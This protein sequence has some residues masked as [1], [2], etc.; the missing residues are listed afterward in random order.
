MCCLFI[1]RDWDNA[2]K[3]GWEKVKPGW[4]ILEKEL[5]SKRVLIPTK[6]CHGPMVVDV[7]DD[8]RI[9]AINTNSFNINTSGQGSRR[10]TIFNENEFYDEIDDYMEEVPHRN[11]II[12]ATRSTLGKSAGYR[13]ARRHFFH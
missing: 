8:L 4:R 11:I 5:Q 2:G 7:G 6:G 9:I 13:S 3:M 12:A 10:F 1:E